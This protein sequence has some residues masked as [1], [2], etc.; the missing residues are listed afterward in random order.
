MVNN[1]MDICETLKCPFLKN[2][3]CTRYTSSF[4]CPVSFNKNTSGYNPEI[5]PNQY[6]L[7]CKN[8]ADIDINELR[9][10]LEKEVL[11]H[12]MSIAQALADNNQWENI[13]SLSFF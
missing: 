1:E 11:Y 8:N 2:H 10:I 6:R 9:E 4:H 7:F 3:S 5:T 13:E 12:S